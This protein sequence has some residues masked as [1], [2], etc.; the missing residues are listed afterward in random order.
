MV[1]LTALVRF[2]TSCAHSWRGQCS[3]GG[4]DGI[5]ELDGSRLNRT[6]TAEERLRNH[7]CQNQT[8]PFAL[9]HRYLWLTRLEFALPFNIVSGPYSLNN[10]YSLSGIGDRS[11]DDT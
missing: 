6:R 7:H 1:I 2:S 4:K 9:S 10:R 5:V 8:Y 3:G 11:R